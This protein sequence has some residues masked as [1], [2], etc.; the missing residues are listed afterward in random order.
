M[1]RLFDILAL[2][3]TVLVVGCTR[4]EPTVVKSDEAKKLPDQEITDFLLKSTNKGKL[5]AI[6]RA[7]RMQKFS[8]ES[9][10]LFDKGVKV[11]FYDADGEHASQL[12][13][14][15]AEYDE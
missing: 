8:K 2:T 11:D 7:G 6:I 12:T 9:L 5:E 1:K 3:I 4:E 15:G 13:A 10:L 14:D